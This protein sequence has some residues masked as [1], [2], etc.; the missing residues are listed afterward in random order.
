MATA[1]QARQNIQQQL[2]QID[3]LRIGEVVGRLQLRR[4]GGAVQ[5]VAER[6]D[7]DQIADHRLALADEAWQRPFAGGGNHTRKQ[8]GVA[9]A[10]Y[11]A[12]TKDALL[13]RVPVQQRLAEVF[14]LR[15]GVDEAR[16]DRAVLAEPVLM[17]FAVEHRAR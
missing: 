5:V 14:G 9:G 2:L 16:P 12:W 13:A 15:V 8:H 3:R 11:R 6:I 17:L 7:V 4:D 10:E 1:V